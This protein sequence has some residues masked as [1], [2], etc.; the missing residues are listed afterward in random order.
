MKKIAV[1][2]N[3][4]KD[5]D[6]SVTKR[7]TSYLEK[8]CAVV[9]FTE[10][11]SFDEMCAD[12]DAL[13]VLGGDGTL[14]RAA[15]KT[16]SKN[17]PVLGINLGKVGYLAEVD[18]DG[19]EES[20]DKLL[21]GNFAVE[22]RF[23]IKAQVVREGVTVSEHIALNDLVI[24]SGSFKKL[25]STK[26]YVNGDFVGAYDADGVV[27]ATPTG[28]TAYSLSA[29][30]P[31]TDSA[32]ELMIVTPICPH[33]LSTRP[34]VVPAD[35]QITAVV[36]ENRERTS[37]LIADGQTGEKLGVGDKVII[38]ACDCKTRLIRLNGMSFYETLRKKISN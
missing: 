18:V 14:L 26:L 27:I 8:R 23:M 24:S 5:K 21:H 22:E 36:G 38:E 1:Y 3:V 10:L 28:S 2:T 33:A 12:A 17:L 6:L 13:I 4:R 20:L 34:L 9:T 15:R 32:M 30:G 35:K 11:D 19:I 29:G 16:C 31:I 7:V 25:V 37:I